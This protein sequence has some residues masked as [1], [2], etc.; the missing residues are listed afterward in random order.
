MRT[1]QLSR[2]TLLS[3]IIA[4]LSSDERFIAAWLTGSF[5]RDAAD[6]LSDLDLN[7]VVARQFVDVLC[8]RPHEVGAGTT[9][10]R[11]ALISRFGKPAVIHE[12]HH[13]APRGG[14]FTY[15]LYTESA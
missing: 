5:G 10:E 11:L 8:A 9:K 15:V 13:N 12:N 2:L 7:V 4:G 1:Y 3:D 6:A 14:T